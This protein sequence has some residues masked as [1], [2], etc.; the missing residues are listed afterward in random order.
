M[1]FLALL[2]SEYEKKQFSLPPVDPIETIE[3][4]M[5]DVGDKPADLVKEYD[6]KDTISKV[7]NYKQPLS[8]N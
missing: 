2:I 8:L 6:D 1:K 5:E 4:R 7:L 3:I